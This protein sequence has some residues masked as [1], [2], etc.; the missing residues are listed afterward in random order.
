MLSTRS[1][2]E[3]ELTA[4]VTNRLDSASSPTF[5]RTRCHDIRAHSLSAEL[6]SMLHVLAVQ[7][8]NENTNAG[9]VKESPSDGLSTWGKEITGVLRAWL[10]D[11]RRL[12]EVLQQ[13]KG[14]QELRR[15][16][17]ATLIRLPAEGN[18]R[19]PAPVVLQPK[20]Q[21]A[22]TEIP[23]LK[24]D[25]HSDYGGGRTRL[26]HEDC[27]S[28]E[29]V[30][31]KDDF[32]QP[33]VARFSDATV[34][35]LSVVDLDR[36]VAVLCLIGGQF[37][38]LHPGGNVLCHMPSEENEPVFVRGQSGSQERGRRWEK[39]FAEEVTVLRLGLS[40]GWRRRVLPC[41]IEGDRSTDSSVYLQSSSAGL[42]DGNRRGR[43]DANE[44]DMREAT[45]VQG[46]RPVLATRLVPS[47]P[48]CVRPLDVYDGLAND[49]QPIDAR[50][51]LAVAMTRADVRDRSDQRQRG[52]QRR[53]EHEH[54]EQFQEQEQQIQDIQQ[55]DIS[56][57]MLTARL[58]SVL[59]RQGRGWVHMQRELPSSLPPPLPPPAA[60]AITAAEREGAIV[61]P[62]GGRITVPTDLAPSTSDER[63]PSAEEDR[64]LASTAEG[65]VTVAS[66]GRE[67]TGDG[68]RV[69]T[70][71]VHA[72][73]PLC[74]PVPPAFTRI[75]LSNVKEL[76]P[77]LKAI[78]EVDTAFRG[79]RRG[80]VFWPI[81]KR[82]WHGIKSCHRQI[83]V[84]S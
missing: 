59:P 62:T 51:P 48:G 79:T 33:G 81:P 67:G 84:D 28:K 37:S 75:L 38:S 74:A 22:L 10:P 45:V 30:D 40:R 82:S 68:L 44:R 25:V 20:G 41:S 76:V 57:R 29:P 53:P 49:G 69:A 61:P 78:L 5:D 70:V 52:C 56:A 77:T 9:E 7:R 43:G 50:E 13:R 42:T 14:F 66:E 60:A 64:Q 26:D 83:A 73:V 6:V 17:D 16:K 32:H 31:G 71:P 3:L 4:I 80:S 47:P 2:S 19:S 8:I 39:D 72:V 11:G 23:G 15:R 18:H 27:S 1:H 24:A 36:I 58:G 46:E 55:E 35:I 54:Q 12:V 65:W 63:Q 34:G 21:G